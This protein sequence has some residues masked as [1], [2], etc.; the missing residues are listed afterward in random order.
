VIYLMFTYLWPV[1]VGRR[2]DPAITALL[3][4]LQAMMSATQPSQRRALASQ[5]QSVIAAIQSDIDLSGYEPHSVRPSQS[6]I[7]ARRSMASDLRA[8][9]GPL[10]LAAEQYAIMSTFLA[11]R[12]RALADRFAESKTARTPPNESVRMKWNALPLF[13]RIEGRLRR[14]EERHVPE[15]KQES[16]G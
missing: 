5:S 2:I 9:T 8:V 13:D 7:L 3:R 6:W 11:E 14:L 15:A 10:L 4:R 1:S 16:G 12:L